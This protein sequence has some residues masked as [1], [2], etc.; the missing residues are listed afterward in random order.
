MLFQTPSPAKIALLSISILTACA[1]VEGVKNRPVTME[2]CDVVIFE[3][4]LWKPK[5]ALDDVSLP[6]GTR[7]IYPDQLVTTDYRA[8][9]LNIKIGKLDRI[10]QVFCG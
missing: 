4:F 7:I 8:D 10:E 6:K 1:P 3:T 2:K 9:R 5:G